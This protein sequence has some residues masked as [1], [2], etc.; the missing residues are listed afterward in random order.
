MFLFLP[1]FTIRSLLFTFTT[2]NI[3][4]YIQFFMKTEKRTWD[5]MEL[6]WGYFQFCANSCSFAA[7]PVASV[8]IL[9]LLVYFRN[10]GKLHCF[11]AYSDYQLH[12]CTCQH[13]FL[14]LLTSLLIHSLTHLLAY[15]LEQSPS[16]KDGRFSD[17][18][19]IPH[20]LWNPKVPFT[21]AC[22]LSL[23]WAISI[24]S[25]SHFLKI[26]LT[27]ILLSTSRSS[28]WSLSLRF[29]HKNPVCTSLLPVHA[30]RPALL[31]LLDLTREKYLVRSTDH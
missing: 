19:E 2:Q 26:Y 3:R 21:S 9:F 18:Q 6:F 11:E 25:P 10:K 27:I 14:N 29:P 12:S 23:S 30:T 15:S 4:E 20:I 24:Q 28:K 1:Y 16:W 31:I 22:H 7:H 8:T 13:V 5:V 17:S